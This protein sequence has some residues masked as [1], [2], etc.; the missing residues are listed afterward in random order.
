MS[1]TFSSGSFTIGS[2]YNY[3]ENVLF[4][5]PRPRAFRD[6]KNLFDHCVHIEKIKHRYRLGTSTVLQIYNNIIQ[7]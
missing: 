5:I 2:D 4:A 7:I 6:R 1:S 3:I